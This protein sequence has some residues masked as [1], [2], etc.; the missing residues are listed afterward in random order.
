VPDP[1]SDVALLP[2][3]DASVASSREAV[4]ALL[5]HRV[6]RSRSAL[7]TAASGLRG[8]RASAAL[9]GADLPLDVVRLSLTDESAVGDA[10]A[11]TQRVVR[12]AL[13]VS[14]ELGS[15]APTFERA[16]LQALAR[17]HVLAAADVLP[18]D[19][20]GRPRDDGPKEQLSARLEALAGLV[21]ERTRTPALVVAA[22]VHGEL[23]A[24][25]PFAWGNGIV[26][27]AAQRL[28]L[29]T[30]G[31]DP[32]ALTV[33]E[34]GH[35]ERRSEY[36]D[37]LTGYES[38]TPEGVARWVVHCADAVALGAREGLAI[39]EAIQRGS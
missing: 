26:A 30:R 33:P 11:E 7:V 2:G 3:V 19:Q 27:R 6:L 1:L 18:A 9:E 37:A 13:R 24:V 21:V 36:V 14:A 35:V 32:K 23:L 39:C 28:V 17:L 10:R 25:R 31:L 29:I 20:L 22:I 15:V 34:V 38:A 12:G 16:P 5:R 8:A 4:D